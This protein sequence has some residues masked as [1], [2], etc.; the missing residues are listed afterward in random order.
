MKS[1]IILSFIFFVLLLTNA[2]ALTI[3]VSGGYRG[4]AVTVTLDKEAFVIFR[5][6]NGT[7]VYAYGT[8]VKF[9]PHVT[10]TLYIEARSGDEVVSR[11]LQIT[12]KPVSDGGASSNLYYSGTVYLPAGTFTIAADTGK[13]Y[14]IDWRTALGALKAASQQKGFGITVKETSWGPFVSCIA[15]KCEG[16]EGATSGWMYQVNGNTPMVGAS[17]Y[18]VKDGDVVVWYFSS[19]MSDTPETSTMVLKITVRY[20]SSESAG[21]SGSATAAEKTHEQQELKS[22]PLMSR[23]VEVKPGEARRIEV[24]ENVTDIT[25]ITSLQV[26]AESGEVRVTISKAHRV[27]GVHGNVLKAFN[28]EVEG[29]EKV[30][31]EFR[32]NKSGVSRD[33]VT[34]MKFNG[35]WI[36]LPT[37]F[38][39]EDEN[40]YHYTAVVRNF[41]TFAVVEKWRNFPLRPSDE[42]VVRALRWLRSVQNDDGGFS[43]P[44]EESSISKTSWAIMAIV[45]AGYDP[46]DWKKNGSSPVDYLRENL[47]VSLGK[48]G[49]A[50]IVR[51]ILAVTAAGE[52]P[53]NFSG[54]DLV[55]LLKDRVRDDGQIGDY[56]YTTIWGIIALSAAGEDVN[57]SV[58]WLVSHQNEDGGF[59]WAVGEESDFDDTAAAI[60]ALV[61]AGVD[62]NSEVIQRALEFLKHGQNDDG[63]MRYFGNSASNAASDAWT[64]QA[65]VA[66]GLNPAEWKRNNK[67][68]VDHLLSLQTDEGYF[69][70][71]A[72]QTSNPGYMTVCAIMALLGKPHPIKPVFTQSSSIPEPLEAGTVTRENGTEIPA[73]PTPA[74]VPTET[75][76]HTTPLPSKTA[77]SETPVERTEEKDRRIPGFGMAA[78]IAA[79]ALLSFRRR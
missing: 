50:D 75:P 48:M 55:S 16:S 65:L 63:G 26:V 31:V 72:H 76:Q 7:P 18:H 36:E 37:E 41:S 49:T 46:S 24:P 5:M 79:L 33:L 56:I 34:L 6:N 59:A 66:A 27:A 74:P 60:Q 32:V 10:G 8:Q 11:T 1:R 67:S 57:K 62:R 2:S 35:T 45:S 22:P 12:E 28:L 21:T 54:V 25:S 3:S 42:P 15:G 70:Y 71:T 52:N 9:L 43:N 58:E 69:R 44:G 23:T 64:I 14:A 30:V 73:T 29:A 78:A 4:E 38:V 51:T 77:V 61:A 20:A 47:N 17:E 40:Y 53:Q 39:R 13:V 68:V 19:S